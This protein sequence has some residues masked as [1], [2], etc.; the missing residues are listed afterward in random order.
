[1][2]RSI[3]NYLISLN[4]NP[5]GYVVLNKTCDNIKLKEKNSNKILDIRW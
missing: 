2:E 3:E 4:L 1:M 5:K